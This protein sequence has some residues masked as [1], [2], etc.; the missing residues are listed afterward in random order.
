M[1]GEKKVNF[2]FHLN[3]DL[4]GQEDVGTTKCDYQVK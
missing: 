2:F 4:L 3:A 1:Q